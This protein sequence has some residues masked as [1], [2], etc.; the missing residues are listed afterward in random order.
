MQVGLGSLGGHRRLA[1]FQSHGPVG[2]MRGTR[3]SGASDLA[4][5]LGPPVATARQAAVLI[6]SRVADYRLTH[7][8][9]YPITTHHDYRRVPCAA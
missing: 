3:A 7:R 9:V 4:V 8:P 2:Q 5:R 1:V 6:K